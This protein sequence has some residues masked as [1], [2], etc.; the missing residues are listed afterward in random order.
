[1]LE[2]KVM[3]FS[4]RYNPLKITKINA[5]VKCMPH[6]FSPTCRLYFYRAFE[7]FSIGKLGIGKFGFGNFGIGKLGIG[8]FGIDKLGHRQALFRQARLSASSVIGNARYQ[9]ARCTELG[10]SRIV[11][12]LPLF[13]SNETT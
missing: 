8:K 1:M 3:S 2:K 4:R 12:S 7:K 6:F 9:Q 11:N 13:N 5:L 10:S